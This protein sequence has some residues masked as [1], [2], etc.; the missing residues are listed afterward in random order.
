MIKEGES[1]QKKKTSVMCFLLADCGN[2]NYKF[3]ENLGE[4]GQHP[5]KLEL[6]RSNWD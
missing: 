5:K 6:E 4:M 1:I 3:L 2:S